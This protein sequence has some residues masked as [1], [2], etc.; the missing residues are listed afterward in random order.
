MTEIHD[1]LTPFGV[2]AKTP[3]DCPSS[4]AAQGAADPAVAAMASL[5]EVKLMPRVHTYTIVSRR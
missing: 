2:L 1:Q 3:S 4:A 5:L